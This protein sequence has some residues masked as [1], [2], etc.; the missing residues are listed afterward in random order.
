MFVKILNSLPSFILTIVPRSFNFVLRLLKGLALNLLN[1]LFKAFSRFLSI[2]AAVL[3]V[4]D[5]F[6]SEFLMQD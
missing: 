2:F 6:L 3:M 4:K 1:K 5:I